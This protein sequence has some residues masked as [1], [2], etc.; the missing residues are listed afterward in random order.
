MALND[1]IE[2]YKLK[3]SNY[4]KNPEDLNIICTIVYDQYIKHK[5]ALD[6]TLVG[7]VYVKND[8]MAAINKFD[9]TIADEIINTLTDILAALKD[10][11]P[12]K[13]TSIKGTTANIGRLLASLC[14]DFNSNLPESLF[15]IFQDIENGIIDL[16]D[17]LNHLIQL[18]YDLTFG[19]AKN[20]LELKNEMLIASL[21]YLFND[22]LYPIL[23]YEQ[24]LLDNG[25]MDLVKKMKSIETCMV[26]PGVCNRPKKDFIHTGSNKVYSDYYKSLFLTD[27][28]GNL[29][30]KK[31]VPNQNKQKKLKLMMD[32]YK[33]ITK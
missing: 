2:E 27:T 28:Q 3:F 18:P 29:D 13:I 31:L 11:L 4:A 26:K 24:F 32:L 25:V 33:K 7:H 6:I 12:P 23:A 19:I 5:N 30:I 20:V 14:V 8:M 22:V 17:D 1:I 21:G 9:G 16:T 10:V 15:N